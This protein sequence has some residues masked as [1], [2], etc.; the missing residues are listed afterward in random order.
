MNNLKAQIVSV[1]GVVVRAEYKGGEPGLGELLHLDRQPNIRFMV[2]GVNTGNILVAI[3]LSDVSLSI[4]EVLLGLGEGLLLP[5]GKSVLGRVFNALGEA[6]DEAG[7]LSGVKYVPAEHE[8]EVEYTPPLNTNIIQTGIKVID[9]F[10]PFVKGYKIGIVGGAGVGKTVLTT[11]LIHNVAKTGQGTAF[12]TGIGE[13]MREAKELH[14]TLADAGLLQN[15]VLYLAQMN[16][17]AALRF[18]V[19]KSAASVA[20][21]FRD[22]YKQDILF[23]ADNTYRFVQA[24]NEL[25][26]LM[27]EASSEGGYQPT[28]FTDVGRFE[29]NLSSSVHGTITTVQSV[30]VP[31]DDITDP[32]VTEIFSQLD[33]VVV[34]SR[35]VAEQGRYP[36]MD[37]LS[38]TSSLLTEEIVGERH[39]QLVREAQTILQ[40]YESLQGTVA[41]IGKTELSVADQEA[42]RQA[43]E[44]M[45][46]FTQ[47]MFVTEKN[48]G[49]K[50][51]YVEREA[52]LKGVEKILRSTGHEAN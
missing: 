32:A 35:E 21:Y 5:V 46:F 37:L 23:F 42:Y 17:N 49:Q 19:A 12:F 41:I 2:V 29:E 26:T 47:N 25:A 28:L 1:K 48:T 7:Q 15:T 52:T 39:V 8:T 30:Y 34:L 9:F 38:T 13:R 33:S 36:A 4:G 31:A 40:K 16:E 3:S 10:A 11:E 51:E 22:E 45:E 50:G 6:I 44:L 20:R 14:A 18:L 24:G 43:E 27:G